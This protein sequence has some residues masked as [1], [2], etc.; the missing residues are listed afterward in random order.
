MY[1]WDKIEVTY[2]GPDYGIFSRQMI[3]PV[4]GRP[5]T[6]LSVNPLLKIC[7]QSPFRCIVIFDACSRRF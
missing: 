4:E 2:A 1:V 7:I 6:T 3:I 5:S